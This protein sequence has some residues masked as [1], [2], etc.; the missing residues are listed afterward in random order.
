MEELVLLTTIYR[1]PLGMTKLVF[2]E[3]GRYMTSD[4]RLSWWTCIDGVFYYKHRELDGWSRIS[5][6]QIIEQLSH[7]IVE[8]GILGD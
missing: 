2:Y 7:S 3:N 6:K 4:N 5:D 1:G 8:N